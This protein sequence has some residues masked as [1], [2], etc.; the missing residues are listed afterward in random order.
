MVQESGD[1]ELVHLF[2]VANRLYVNFYRQWLPIEMVTSGLD[3]IEKFVE[4]V[5]QLL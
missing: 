1:K 4:K 3:N 2:R 5:E